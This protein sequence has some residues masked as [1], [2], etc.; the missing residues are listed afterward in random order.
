MIALTHHRC[1]SLLH[2]FPGGESYR[3]LIRRLGSVVIEVEQQVIPTL[4]VSHVSIL[5]VLIAYFRN[6][7]IESCMNIEVPLH[8][9]IKFTP[10][11]G[12]GWMEE[13]IP[14]TSESPVVMGGGAVGG[15]GSSSV[16]S[17]GVVGAGN[18]ANSKVGTTLVPVQSNG[19][20]SALGMEEAPMSPIWG[21][22]CSR[23]RMYSLEQVRGF[24]ASP[25][26]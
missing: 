14:L 10:V 21:D 3:D 23:S 9:V 22:H 6:T 17:L 24:P 15:S 12:G 5:Q 11:R 16:G 1:F 18:N 19:E 4:V 2:S 26:C 25:T 7:R 20:I 8:T 13:R